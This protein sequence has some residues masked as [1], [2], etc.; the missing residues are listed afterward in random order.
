MNIGIIVGLACGFLFAAFMSHKVIMAL[1]SGT[2]ALDV[3]IFG[4]KTFCKQDRPVAF[5]LTVGWLGFWLLPL[6][7]ICIFG[8][9]AVAAM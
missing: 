8:A 2:I 4:T 9:L 6:W 1:K 5:F 7:G 3:G